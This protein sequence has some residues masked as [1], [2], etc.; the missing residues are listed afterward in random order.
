[1]TA[2]IKFKW[3]A[4]L[5]QGTFID[6]L[7]DEWLACIEY[8]CALWDGHNDA[9]YWYN[10]RANISVLNG[11]AWKM[12]AAALEESETIKRFT[13][14][15]RKGR[16][17]LHIT[18]PNGDDCVIE[19]KQCWLY[20]EKDVPGRARSKFED[21]IRSARVNRDSDT[22]YACTF[23]VPSHRL[24][25]IWHPN[26]IYHQILDGLKSAKI[27]TDARAV[28]FPYSC[29]NLKSRE[30]GRIYPGVMLF[31]TQVRSG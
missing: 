29:R 7:L 3:T 18:W 13:A 25:A 8:Y 9:P 11:A 30:D 5:T 15:P 31:L 4:K 23:L 22:S 27:R 2:G 10:E 1:M 24:G 28:C 21:A 14:G 26:D 17:D 12:G 19:A 20:H 16:T 6:A